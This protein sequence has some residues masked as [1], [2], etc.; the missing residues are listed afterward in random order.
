MRTF[1]I[2]MHNI[3]HLFLN[4]IILK[5][6]TLCHLSY[7]NDKFRLFSFAACNL[8]YHFCIFCL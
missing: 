7:S 3:S 4:E 1:I 2:I 8:F 5:S 6:E